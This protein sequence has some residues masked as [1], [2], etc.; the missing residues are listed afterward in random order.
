MSAAARRNWAE[1]LIEAGGLCLFIMSLCLWGTVIGHPDS[2]IR[3]AVAFGVS[4]R[5]LIGLVIGATVAAIIYSPWGRRSGAHLNPAIT[6]TY[7]RLGKI[8][9]GDALFYV[10]AQFAGGWLG[11]LSASALLGHRLAD[12]AVRFMVTVPGRSGEGVAFVAELVIAS[13]LMLMI[14]V[15]TNSRRLAPYTGLFAALMIALYITVES[16]LSGM[17]MNPARSLGTALPARI[18]TALWIYFMAPLAGMLLAA[19]VY[20]RL[21]GK[22]RVLCAKLQHDRTGRCLFRCAYKETAD[23]IGSTD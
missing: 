22:R 23:P 19:E 12:P 13:A 6:L 4:R 9:G 21:W 15:T 17:S 5:M 10:A 2:P 14:L 16:P 20:V 3:Q 18:F 1:Y 11:A 7:Y 8:R